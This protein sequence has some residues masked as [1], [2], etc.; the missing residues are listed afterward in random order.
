[1]DLTTGFYDSVLEGSSDQIN[2]EVP[3]KGEV[4]VRASEVEIT[5]IGEDGKVAGR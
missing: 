3:E 4:E 2:V 1:M 5:T